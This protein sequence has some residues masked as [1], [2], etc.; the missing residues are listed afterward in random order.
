MVRLPFLLF[1]LFLVS[2]NSGLTA[3]PLDPALRE[4]CFIRIDPDDT[5]AEGRW[6]RSQTQFQLYFP[7]PLEAVKAVLLDFA[8]YPSFTPRLVRTTILEAGK[9]HSVIRQQYE[10]NILGYRY[11][12]E[13]ELALTEDDSRLPDAWTLSWNLV[14]SDGS[15]G[16]SV[17]SWSLE[18]CLDSNGHPITKVTHRNEGLVAR[19]YPLQ[20][21]I[22]RKVGEAELQR[23]LYAVRDEASR[24]E[25]L[26]A[27]ASARAGGP[28]PSWR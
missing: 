9:S 6:I 8:S 7:V 21:T 23:S 25:G 12:T 5:E 1:V 20:L 26:L 28:E 22:M 16:S 10:I 13:Y 3:A 24:R 15:I 18:A 27:R 19:K 17:G 4:S 2:V 11:P 14:K